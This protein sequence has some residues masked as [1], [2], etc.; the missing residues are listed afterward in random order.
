M[1]KAHQEKLR[2]S[3][4]KILDE[5]VRICTLENINYFLDYGTLLG[6]VRHK[7]YIPWDDDIDIGML[8]EDY[9]KFLKVAPLKLKDEFILCYYKTEPNHWHTFAKIRLKDTVMLEEGNKHLDMNF[10]IWVDIF[11]YDNISKPNSFGVKLRKKIFDIATTF[12]AL[13]LDIEF[14][15]DKEKEK[16]LKR[17]SKLFSLK[18]L[19]FI[20]EL[21]SKM[22]RNNKTNYISCFDE[23]TLKCYKGLLRD[24][25]I[26]CSKLLFEEKEYLVPND[27][28]YRLTS[29]Y[30]DYMTIPPVE[31]Q[32]NHSPIK[33][34]FEDGEIIENK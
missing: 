16:K 25:M 26:P 27:Y 4:I 34:V 17:I 14:Y 10:G 15:Q 32:I 33:L 29:Q 31:K 20:R 19:Y 7:G 8:R 28:D 9:E 2:K 5:I 21:V 1:D 11:P 22:N 18:F 24:K 13:K 30:N 23:G 3:Q 12:I 6:A